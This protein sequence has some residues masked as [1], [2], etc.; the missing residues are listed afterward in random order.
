MRLKSLHCSKAR[1]DVSLES[2]YFKILYVRVLIQGYKCSSAKQILNTH[3]KAHSF[4]GSV[5]QIF[6]AICLFYRYLLPLFSAHLTPAP[7]KRKFPLD[8]QHI[9]SNQ[10]SILYIE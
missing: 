6:E 2:G 9:A 3:G 1:F 4:H 5:F 8:F 10:N 7:P